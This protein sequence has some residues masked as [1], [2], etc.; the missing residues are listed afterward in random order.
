M[1]FGSTY[2]KASAWLAGF[3]LFIMVIA[4]WS[5]V[6]TMKEGPQ[7]IDGTSKAITNLFKGVF[8]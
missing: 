7:L 5:R 1:M 4:A 8:R 2:G 3:F 6:S